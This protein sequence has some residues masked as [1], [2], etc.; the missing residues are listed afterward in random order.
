MSRRLAAL[1]GRSSCRTRG[2]CVL[3]MKLHTHIEYIHI[4][5]RVMGTYSYAQHSWHLPSLEYLSRGAFAMLHISWI[6]RVRNI[7]CVLALHLL[8]LLVL[9]FLLAPRLAR[10][11][12]LSLSFPQFAILNPFWSFLIRQQ[13]APFSQPL[14]KR[15]IEIKLSKGC[16]WN[17]R[18]FRAKRPD[19]HPILL[20]LTIDWLRAWPRKHPL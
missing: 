15:E 5:G 1:T 6:E 19:R 7:L 16:S 17:L 13:H 10:L 20:V 4:C 14:G 8:V 12:C 18:P 11:G 2:T 9:L 3:I